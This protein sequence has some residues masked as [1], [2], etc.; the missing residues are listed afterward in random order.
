VAAASTYND[1]PNRSDGLVDLVLAAPNNGTAPGLRELDVTAPKA[2]DV[3]ENPN[4]ETLGANAAKLDVGDPNEKEPGVGVP[5]AVAGTAPNEKEPDGAVP[6]AGAD[7]NEKDVVSAGPDD[8]AGSA[9]KEEEPGVGVPDA[10]APN[11]KE[12]VPDAGAEEADAGVSTAGIGGISELEG[13]DGAL[14]RRFVFC[15]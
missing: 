1:D 9:P 6:D 5:D 11:E 10:V 13:S 4:S 7:P 8:G 14:S 2:G 12:P 3:A 15:S